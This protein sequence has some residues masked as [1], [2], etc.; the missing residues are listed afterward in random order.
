[1]NK[2]PYVVIMAQK[3]AVGGGKCGLCRGLF[4]RRVWPRLLGVKDPPCSSVVALHD[5]GMRHSRVTSSL[6]VTNG[7]SSSRMPQDSAWDC[8]VKRSAEQNLPVS[9]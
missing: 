8:H 1:V 7:T 5:D 3:N 6:P 9:I 2:S 4:Q